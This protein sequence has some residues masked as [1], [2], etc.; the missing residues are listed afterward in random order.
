MNTPAHKPLIGL[1]IGDLNGIGTEL[2]I[3]TISDHRLLELFTPVIF[4]SNKVINFYRKSVPEINFNYQS[5][6]DFTRV[7]H[8]QINVF[9]CWEEEVQISPGQLNDIGGKYAVCSLQSAVMALK[10]NKIQGLVT[11]PIHKKN[12]ES[13]EF[14][15][16][17]H[18]PYLK[19]VFGV[20]DVVM[21]MVSEKFR[22]G[23]VTEHV[24]I[25]DV[26]SLITK[27]N[28]LSKL[29][30]MRDSLIKDFGID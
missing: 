16:T 23:L 8:K 29:N 25:K 24:P 3:K 13:S 12:T 26:A 6:K 11:A 19:S 9:N 21:F 7:N 30:L 28:I 5:I 10:E 20:K 15:F 4:A 27:E 18:T 1:T 14:P 2:I 22:V 17:G